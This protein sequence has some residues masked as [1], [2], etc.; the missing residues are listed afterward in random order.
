M[1]TTKRIRKVAISERAIIARINRKLRQ[2]PNPEIIR[3]ART[4]RQAEELGDYY[5]ALSNGV[6]R[7]NVK[8]EKLGRE[9]GVLRPWEELEAE[10]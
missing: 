5:T 7:T 10:R 3:T 2:Q 8:L 6:G 1:A 4:E 9:L